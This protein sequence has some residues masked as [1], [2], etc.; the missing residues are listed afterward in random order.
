MAQQIIFLNIAWMQKYQGVDQNDPPINGGSYVDV[1]G[2]AHECCNFLVQT[3]GAL[4]GH[5]ETIK[6]YKDKDTGKDNH[7]DREIHL[8][9]MF[10]ISNVSA[11]TQ[12]IDD[13]LV[14]WLATAPSGG[15]RVVGW[16]KNATVYRYR[17]FYNIEARKKAIRKGYLK[18]STPEQ[19]IFPG[20]KLTKTHKNSDIS[21]FRVE[22]C[23]TDAVLLKVVERYSDDFRFFE[24]DE[25]GKIVRKGWPGQTQWTSWYTLG[26]NAKQRAQ[27]ILN[28][29]NSYDNGSYKARKSVKSPRSSDPVARQKTELAAIKKAEQFYK[30]IFRGS[31]WVDRSDENL[32]YDYDLILTD[33]S[34]F[35]IEVKGRSSSHSEVELTPN[36]YTFLKNYAFTGTYRLCIVTHALNDVSACV[37]DLTR[38][39]P[40]KMMIMGKSY[41]IHNFR[42]DGKASDASLRVE[43]R[44]GARIG[45]IA[46]S[47]VDHPKHENIGDTAETEYKHPTLIKFEN[48]LDEFE[49]A[50]VDHRFFFE[51]LESFKPVLQH[52][53]DLLRVIEV[54]REH[55][56][57]YEDYV[58]EEDEDDELDIV[59]LEELIKDEVVENLEELLNIYPRIWRIIPP[60]PVSDEMAD[61]KS[62][63]EDFVERYY[64]ENIRSKGFKLYDVLICPAG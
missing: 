25:E 53:D 10:Q 36:E 34:I 27:E 40:N 3:D 30:Q 50:L 13:V 29:I 45:N 7:I 21:S 38:Y 63:V 37:F 54:C 49:E 18:N 8:E 1:N 56:D 39:D 57:E 60:V 12:K 5:V 52:I 16:W 23:E 44:E 35:N 62:D 4:R 46:S 20:A 32:G 47:N 14:I 58:D 31:E 41:H 28:H 11:A 26:A 15:R 55:I 6:K 33:G 17:Q 51:K 42:I 61:L 2:T 22:C 43:L 64:E 9:N 24:V 48:A 19:T 59:E